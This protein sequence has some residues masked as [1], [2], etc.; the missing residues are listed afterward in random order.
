MINLKFP[1]VRFAR[2]AAALLLLVHTRDI[3]RCIEST[4]FRFARTT[5]LNVGILVRTPRNTIGVSPRTIILAFPFSVFCAPAFH[6]CAMARRV[7]GSA[8]ART[9]RHMPGILLVPF[10]GVHYHAGH[11]GT[12]CNPPLVVS[13]KASLAGCIMKIAALFGGQPSRMPGALGNTSHRGFAGAFGTSAISDG[14]FG[15]VPFAA[16]LASEVKAFSG[17]YGSSPLRGWF[18]SLIVM[19]PA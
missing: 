15:N 1:L 3:F 2:C 13:A 16:R 5:I 19:S 9:S 11:A 6:L 18:H 8:S 12:V 17:R 14:S 7:F 10:L 4:V